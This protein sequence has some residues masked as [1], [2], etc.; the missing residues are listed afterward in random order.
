MFI[1]SFVIF[2]AVFSFTQNPPAQLVQE[3]R[4]VLRHFSGT[5]CA[6]LFDAAGPGAALR[7]DAAGH[8]AVA[9]R[10]SGLVRVAAED[11]TGEIGGV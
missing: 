6:V 2:R 1:I 7:L 4:A 10:R 3:L 5:A 11:A 9:R 8:G